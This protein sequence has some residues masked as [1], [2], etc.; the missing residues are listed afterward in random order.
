[1]S[2]ESNAGTGPVDF[3]FTTGY[4]A[5]VLLELKHITN[6]GYWDGPAAQLPTYLRAQQAKH[7]MFIAI[8]YRDKEISS[9]R[10]T[11]LAKAVREAARQ[12]GFRLTSETVD[13]RMQRLPASRR[14]RSNASSSFEGS[15][16]AELP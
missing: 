3:L 10:F 13:A 8:A 16:L 5:T 9:R 4:K 7:A 12:T 15:R 6:S 2:P 11:E 14:R 1:M